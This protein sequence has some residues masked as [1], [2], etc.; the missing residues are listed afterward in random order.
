[1][2]LIA[3]SGS[4]KTDW[5][6][7]GANTLFTTQGIN[8]FHQDESTILRILQ[9]ELL[10]QLG[11][12][13]V[14]RIFFY[15]AGCN[16]ALAPRMEKML[17]EAFPSAETFAASDLLGAA[18][19]LCGRE[20]GI[21]AI[22]GTGSNTCFFNGKE[23]A[24][25]VPP[26]GYVLGDEGSGAT[27][28]KRFL[29]ALYKGFLSPT[30]RQCFE[31]DMKMDYQ[32]VIERIY[33]QPLANRFLASLAPFIKQHMQEDEALKNVVRENFRDFFERN[34]SQYPHHLPVNAVGSIAHHFQDDLREVAKEKGRTIGNILQKPIDGL[35]RH[36]TDELSR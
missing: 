3:D 33:R 22:L 15:G 4:T 30:T 19:A 11:E 34:I 21:A 8:P 13:H 20:A 25:N 32:Q 28:G 12:A 1:M 14:E 5:A 29:N 31:E 17:K 7:S 23:I 35:V 24:Q 16:E 10:P 36:H 18:R 9:E 27:L 26:L 2:I 6:L